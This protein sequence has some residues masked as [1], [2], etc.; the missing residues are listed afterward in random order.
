[1]ENLFGINKWI[2]K[3]DIR[4][5]GASYGFVESAADQYVLNFATEKIKKEVKEPFFLFYLTKNSHSPFISPKTIVKDWRSLNN[6]NKELIGY[7][8][9]RKPNFEDYL[10]SIKYQWDMLEDFILSNGNDDDVFV[11]YGDH[12][13][14]DL[15]QKEPHGMHTLVHVIAKN[16]KFIDGFGQYGFVEDIERIKEPIKHEGFYTA[17]L[18]QFLET[19]GEKADKL[20]HRPEGIQL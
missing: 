3:K 9:L 6:G 4:F 14:H 15:A 20:D 17:F 16:Q 18:R 13:P 5:T 11:L 10:D 19:F 2:L 8:F 1:M 7:Q 12:Q